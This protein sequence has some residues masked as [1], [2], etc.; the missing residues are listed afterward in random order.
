MLD[1]LIA[2]TFEHFRTP[3]NHLTRLIHPG[4][5][6]TLAEENAA[7]LT[8]QRRQSSMRFCGMPAEI[9]AADLRQTAVDLALDHTQS[10]SPNVEATPTP[11]LIVMGGHQPELFHPG[12]WFKNFLL[13][14]LTRVSDRSTVAINLIVDHDDSHPITVGVPSAD[15]ENSLLRIQSETAHK[16]ADFP[17]PIL[18]WELWYSTA[19]D[20]WASFPQRVRAAANSIAPTS[21]LVVESIWPTVLNRLEE[22]WPVGWAIA[23]GRHFVERCN[24]SQTLELPY[25]KIADHRTFHWFACHVA[26]DIVAF[27]KT[28]HE[29]REEYRDAHKIRSQTHPVPPLTRDGEWLECPFWVYSNQQKMRRPLY[30]RPGEQCVELSDRNGWLI[31]ITDIADPLSVERQFARLIESG[32][33][34]RPRA[35]M[36]SMFARL[37]LSDLFLHGIGGAKYDQLTDMII[38]RWVG[39]QPP[40]FCVATATVQYDFSNCHS[41]T[42]FVRTLRQAAS[43]E[44]RGSEIR[45]LLHQMQY[46]PETYLTESLDSD[47]CLALARKS[48][49][50]ANIP[51]RGEKQEWHREISQL[52]VDLASRLSD[53]RM[54][55]LEELRFVSQRQRQWGMGKSREYSIATFATDQLIRQLKG[56]TRCDQSNVVL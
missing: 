34:I 7:L 36:T 27:Q 11:E 54:A 42:E 51:S 44:Q 13:D 24:G 46:H 38:R 10:Y 12:V 15:C 40:A 9:M 3:R 5:F 55:L 53:R 48:E 8:Q 18:P 20:A 1:D 37:F 25:S 31:Q 26:Y 47:V 33:R 19:D 41:D 30:S 16:L 52:N 4:A 23:A 45:F 43:P 49:L 21:M 22:G 2:P 6:C 56:L 35:L 29:C 17:L 28:V 14:K 50:L 39:W 32:L